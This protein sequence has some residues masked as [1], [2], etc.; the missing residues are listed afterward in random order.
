MRDPKRI[1]EILESLREI[2]KAQP[3]LRFHQLIYIL[4]NEYSLANKGL[5]KVESA[6]I[7]GFKRTGFDFFNVEDQSFQEFLEL[8]LEQGRWGNEA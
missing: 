6:E 8:S 4:Q 5:G 2:W 7:D 3:N 1:D